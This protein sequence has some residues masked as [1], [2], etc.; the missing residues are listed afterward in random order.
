MFE[1]GK[2]M[3]TV[4]IRLLQVVLG[5]SLSPAYALAT[6]NLPFST[7]YNCAEQNQLLGWLNCDGLTAGGSWTTSLG[8]REQITTAANYGG[9]SGGRGQRHWIGNGT[10]NNSGSIGYSFSPT[11]ELWVR[12]YVRW[13]PGFALAS[14]GGSQKVLYFAGGGCG[15]PNGCYFQFES[16]AFKMVV[17]GHLYATYSYGWNTLNGGNN[18]A[19]GNWYC[20]EIHVKSETSSGAGNGIAQW[21]VD[22]VLRHDH[23]NVNFGNSSTGFSFFML[24]SNAVAATVGGQDMYNDIDDVTVSKT[25]RIGC[26]GGTTP[27][28]APQNLQLTP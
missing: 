24:P 25:G 6:I 9:G 13:Q 14:S 12:W 5:L 1:R 4:F 8:S 15:Q 26:T 7:T 20:F 27:P 10:N 3:K 11:N 28:A 17:A 23:R 18:S 22:G 21:W 16:S 2:F 19:T